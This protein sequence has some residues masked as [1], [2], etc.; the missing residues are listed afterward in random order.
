IRSTRRLAEAAGAFG[1]GELSVRIEPDGPPE[2]AEATGPWPSMR[3]TA[4]PAACAGTA[5]TLSGAP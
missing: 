4:V 1:D 5:V 2:L 3:L